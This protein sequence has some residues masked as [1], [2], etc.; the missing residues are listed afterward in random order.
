L[1]THYKIG[2][3]IGSTT[4]KIAVVDS[5]QKLI[6]SEYRRHNTQIYYTLHNLLES[7]KSALG[8]CEV[9]PIL[10]GSAGLGIS[11]R[12]EIPFVQE[13]VST[14]EIIRNKFPSVKTLIDIGGE[15]SKMIFY[16]GK[17]TPDIRMNG[18]CAGG[19]GAFIDQM[20]ALLNISLKELNSLANKSSALYPIASRCGVFAKTD[21]Q[22]LVSR[23]I[24]IQDIAASIFHAIAIQTINTLAR[25]FDI[26][27][28]VI[29]SGG[30]FTFMPELQNAFINALKISKSDVIH[31]NNTELFPAIGACYCK[32]ENPPQLKISNFQKILSQASKNGI[33][34]D[35]LSPLFENKEIFNQ[36][37]NN[38]ISFEIPKQSI[39]NYI[40]KE[41]FIGIDSG[42]TTTKIAVIGK[43]NE[44]LFQYYKNNDGKPIEAVKNGLLQFKKV[45]EKKKKEILIAKTAVTGYGED[46]IKASFSIDLSLVE[47][48]AHYNAAKFFNKN[49]SFIL[50]IGGQDM[51]AIFVENNLINRIELNES[52]SSGCGSFI[53]TFGKS[54]GYSVEEFSQIACS[55]KAPCD[56]GTR[57]TVFMNSK[58]KQAL[59]ENASTNDIA[60]GLS[61]S[62]IKNA[63]HKVLKIKDIA[64][65]GDNIVVQGGTFRNPSVQK[66]LETLV[67]K[68]VIC[69]DLPGL[70]GAFGASLFAKN[71]YYKKSNN[72][73]FSSFK[74]TDM[75]NFGFNKTQQLRCKACE[76]QCIVTK[77]YS[78]SKNIYYSGNK[79]E[80]IFSNKGQKN[81]KGINLFDYKNEL[82]F[83]PAVKNE[84]SEG[85]KIGIP[86]ALN[87]YENFPFWNSLLS[88]CGI[89]LVLS[90]VSTNSI[91]EKGLGTIM[92]DSI[93]FPAKLVHGHIFELI[94]KKVDRIFY[95]MVFYEKNEFEESNNHFNCPIVSSYA[96]VIKSSINTLQ[97]HSVEFD[98][99]EINFNNEK[100]LK[101]ACF[102][103]LSKLNIK[104]S[105][106]KK[107]LDIA[108]EAQQKFKQKIKSKAIEIIEKSKK[109]NQLLIVLAGRPYHSDSLINHKIPEILVNLGVNVVTED[110]VPLSKNK[111]VED[112][113]IISQWSYPNR[114]YNAAQWVAEQ[115]ENVQFVLFNS[116]GCGPDAIVIDECNEILKSA[117]KIHTLIRIDE[118]TST[119]SVKL[120]LRSL[121]ESLKIRGKSNFAQNQRISTP[122]FEEKDKRRTIIGPLFSDM[123]SP[124]LPALFKL[125]GYQYVNLQSPDKTSVEYG[126]KYSNNEIC[127]PATI[128]VGDI[129]RALNSGKYKRDELAVT[130]TQTGGQCRASTYLS[131]I[132]KAM[133]TAG[134]DDIPVI[135]IGLNGKVINQQ[136]G[137]NINWKLLVPITFV[138]ILFC[139]A[140]S[141]MYYSMVVR[142]IEKGSSKKLKLKYLNLIN[143]YIVENDINGVF[144]LLKSAVD[145]FNNVEVDDKFYPKIGIVGEIY[146]KYNSFGNQFIIDWLIEHGVEVMVP[147][148]NDFLTQEFVNVKVNKKLGLTEAKFGDFY[149]N[150]FEF[151][152]NKYFRKIDKIFSNYKLY[153]PFHKIREMSKKA[154]K[155]LSLANQFG[156][157]WLIPAEIA[158]FSEQGINNIVSVQPFGCIANQ[159]V[160]KGIEK[161]L[162]DNYPNLNLLF[163]D[164]DDGISNVNVI[165]RLH[166]LVKNVKT[167]MQV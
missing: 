57:C 150:Y 164:F 136:S 60:A 121:I 25:G 160:S 52:C 140:I 2:L 85:I 62:V 100:L 151:K 142:E 58:V 106:Y 50:D 76:N 49:V 89:D 96:D 40:G 18:S 38:N 64:E 139:D 135:S 166:F 11:E 68:K 10:T 103:Y 154:E 93:C 153:S 129:I 101:S 12:V 104:R 122:T 131:L 119:G 51:K 156:E 7:A 29:L 31:T 161:K 92:S 115:D 56:L 113:H 23:K 1:N 145:D 66:S 13:L 14:T 143:N 112:L 30:P 141:M 152:A 55:S 36:W 17:K 105:V 63:L 88:N 3:D 138:S 163:L 117:G 27:S 109:N 123:Y 102:K 78:S 94:E 81:Q 53:E 20:A 80:N 108:I 73:S 75:E 144:Q 45:L 72:G 99:L 95:P 116:F 61:I 124:I 130:L 26:K 148:L 147:P 15:D 5:S 107:A 46:L 165:N 91:Y 42:S 87:I 98:A 65:L 125:A 111:T 79:C 83:Q 146:V 127:Y 59:R 47:T 16:N 132:K 33:T 110:S 126:L 48:I 32:E 21:V 44:L 37:K 9:Q 69:S 8:D 82:L 28:K 137:F 54:L 97:N 19:T 35:R 157:G 133:V 71:N 70:M 43:N 134:F 74:L 158:T 159:V 120:R 118:I 41:C 67:G 77:F 128:V 39:K 149:I 167:E 90:E 155:I 4:A 114:I 84:N 34:C 24:P 86:R 162:K 6:F 22:N